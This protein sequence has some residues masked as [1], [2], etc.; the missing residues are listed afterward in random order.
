M[1]EIGAEGR[2]RRGKAA[3]PPSK[4]TPEPPKVD[5]EAAK[6]KATVPPKPG[7]A[8]DDTGAEG[9]LSTFDFDLDVMDQR[10]RP[11]TG[12]FSAKVLNYG[13]RI[14]VGLM[15][16][17]LSNHIPVEALDPTTRDLMEMVAHLEVALTDRPRWA[18]DLLALYDYTVIGAI[19]R[20]VASYE[21]RF[22]GAIDSESGG[23]S[24]ENG[25][26]AA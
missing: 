17:Q 14:R 10:G 8:N 9:L 3:P 24:D 15:R 12:R 11:W 16:S 18:D 20:E 2:R 25:Q 21:N 7:P 1:S 13:D 22:H 19:Y 5:L 4:A 23:S 6:A 26:G